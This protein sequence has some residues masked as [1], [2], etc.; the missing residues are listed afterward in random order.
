[1]TIHLRFVLSAVSPPGPE[2]ARP[3]I[4]LIPLSSIIS[5]CFIF[6][7]FA[8][9]TNL[10]GYISFPTVIDGLIFHMHRIPSDPFILL[11]FLFDSLPRLITGSGL[12]SSLLPFALMFFLVIFEPGHILRPLYCVVFFSFQSKALS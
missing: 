10:I 7:Y 8:S 4:I 3:D 11:I 12:V 1:M 6:L 9:D 2:L 5:K